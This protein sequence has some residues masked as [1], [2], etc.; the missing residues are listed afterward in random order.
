M[1]RAARIDGNQ[2]EVIKQLRS[3]GCSVQPLHTV[4]GGVPDLLVGYMGTNYLIEL[5][6]GSKKPSE[7]RLNSKQVEWHTTWRGTVVKV[8]SWEEAL[9]VIGVRVV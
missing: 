5:K 7:R 9:A 4:G 8:E 1:R 6:D 3:H 2:E